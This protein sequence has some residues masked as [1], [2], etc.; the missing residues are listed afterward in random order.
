MKMGKSLKK[1]IRLLSII[2]FTMLYGCAKSSSVQVSPDKKLKLQAFT[3]DGFVQFKILSHDNKVLFKQKNAVSAYHR[4][5]IEWVNNNTV[6]L[7][8]SDVGNFFWKKKSNDIW[9]KQRA[10]I[11]VSPDGKYI[12]IASWENRRKRI[13]KLKIGKPD[14]K[15]KLK[16]NIEAY[17]NICSL[18]A[19]NI[20]VSDID[21]R[22]SWKKPGLIKLKGNKYI[23]TWEKKSNGVWIMLPQKTKTNNPT[24]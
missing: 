14:L 12:V 16:L 19:D 13:I 8:S 24:H 17:E 10:N 5:S 6:L 21:G 2:L 7:K 1:N 23:Y 3:K 22:L 18:P 20:V 15:L 9:L 4:W 11:A